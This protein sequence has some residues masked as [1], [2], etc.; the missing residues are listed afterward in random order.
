MLAYLTTVDRA[1]SDLRRAFDETVLPT[2]ARADARR[3]G[4][5]AGFPGLADRAREITSPTATGPGL[6]RAA[7]STY[8]TARSTSTKQLGRDPGAAGMR[9]FQHRFVRENVALIRGVVGDTRLRLERLIGESIE[10]G[11]LPGALAERIEEEFGMSRRRAQFVARDQTLKAANQLAQD[12]QRTA[13]VTE[14]IWTTSGDER[15]RDDH[16]DL[17]GTRQSF[18]SP[19]IVDKRTGRRAHPGIDY[20][21]RCTAFPI[22]PE[23]PFE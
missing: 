8:A 3:P 19:P 12:H 13:G 5:R 18:D 16:A 6:M 2:L 4:A 7:E 20:Q 15:V 1:I 11:L 14:Y 23:N 17:E 22:L 9:P 10:K 21:C